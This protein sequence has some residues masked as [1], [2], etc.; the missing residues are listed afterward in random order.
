MT[1]P[2]VRLARCPFCGSLARIEQRGIWYSAHC[3]GA[4]SV[5]PRPTRDCSECVV[6][7]RTPWALSAAAVARD[8]NKRPN[9]PGDVGN[10]DPV[11]AD[12][13]RDLPPDGYCVC[14]GRTKN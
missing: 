12:C 10:P 11:C 8:W 6:Q 4:M 13:G 9:A 5:S 14:A 7:P 1:P 3:V 2:V